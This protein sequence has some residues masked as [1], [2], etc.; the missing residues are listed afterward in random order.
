VLHLLIPLGLVSLA[1]FFF[2]FS[3]VVRSIIRMRRHD[4]LIHEIKAA[5]SVIGRVID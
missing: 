1:L 3:L 5:H 4:T 2:G